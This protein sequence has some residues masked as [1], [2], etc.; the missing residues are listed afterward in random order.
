MVPAGFNRIERDSSLPNDERKCRVMAQDVRGAYVIPF[1]VFRRAGKWI[2]ANHG[3]SLEVI[4]IAWRYL[5]N[6]S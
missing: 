2:N 6:P 5:E 1:P 4:V 3:N